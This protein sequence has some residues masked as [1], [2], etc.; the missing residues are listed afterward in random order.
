M[1]YFLLR[2]SFGIML[3]LSLITIVVL[4]L[5]VMTALNR[6]SSDSDRDRGFSIDFNLFDYLILRDLFWWGTWS[7]YPTTIGYDQ[8]ARRRQSEGNFFLDCFSFLFGDGNP[9]A[10][11][12]ERRWQA[13]AQV[14]KEHKGV[15]TAELLAPYTG[16]DPKNENAVL[17]V[18]VRFDGRPEVTET[19]NIVYVFP[20]LQVRAAGD[21]E[22]SQGRSRSPQK[23]D[24]SP[25][26]GRGAVSNYL[27]EFP[28]KFSSASESSLIWVTVLAGVNFAGAWWLQAMM[29]NPMYAAILW[30]FRPLIALLV[31]YGTLF[32]G[33]PIVRWMALKVMN[34]QIDS[35]NGKRRAYA[36]QLEKPSAELRLKLQQA[37]D[38]KIS[39]Q[40]LSQDKVAYTTEKDA[41][42]QEF[43]S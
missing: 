28:W 22:S 4:I 1:G 34:S 27:Q 40:L 18:L 6:G 20:S 16:A 35:R 39:E 32:V 36:A 14:V 8:P 37:Q 38:Y 11:L 15:A 43:E 23:A 33:I 30:P 42:E 25:V 26:G 19:G 12:E 21:N 31:L 2:I 7:S 5:V 10:H 29:F 13:I 24:F 9:N 41:L 17:P 3:V